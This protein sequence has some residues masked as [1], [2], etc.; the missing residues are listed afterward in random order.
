MRHTLFWLLWTLGHFLGTYN[1]LHAAQRDYCIVSTGKEE[2]GD[3][4]N[5]DSKQDLVYT[6]YIVHN[7]V[8]DKPLIAWFAKKAYTDVRLKHTSDD[9]QEQSIALDPPDSSIL[10]NAYLATESDVKNFVQGKIKEH[11]CYLLTYASPDIHSVQLKLD[12]LKAP[13]SSLSISSNNHQD[14]DPNQPKQGDHTMLY[15][16]GGIGVILVL[17]WLMSGR[18]SQA[19]N[20]KKVKK[21]GKRKKPKK[22]VY[23]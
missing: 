8:P 3:E 7:K 1:G 11:D 20:L 22:V 2:A 21:K 10:N 16:V 6:Y 9:D 15:F 4:G 18:D 14:N 5:D 19:P 13:F 23:V 12:D 17:I